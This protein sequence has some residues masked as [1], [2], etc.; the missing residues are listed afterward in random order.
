MD[1]SPLRGGLSLAFSLVIAMMVH[2]NAHPVLGSSLFKE[3]TIWTKGENGIPSHFVYGLTLTPKGTLL[4]FTE[5]RLTPRD[6]DPHH[7]V[8]KR[9]TDQG[10]TWSN[11]LMIERAD[12]TY[13]R[14]QGIE[15]R[16]EC[17]TNPAALVE[18][19][20]GHIFIF[21]AVNEGI[22]TGS[23]NMQ[24]YTRNF[25]RFSR[26]EGLTWSDRVD[27][28]DLLNATEDGRPNKDTEGNWRVD[29]N[30]FP[31]DFLGRAFHMP[32]PGHGLQ[33]KSGR[34]LMQFW[35]RTALGTA[36]GKAIPSSERAYGL[37]LLYSDDQ[38]RSW[39]TG[40]AFGHEG[41]YTESRLVQFNDG[42]LYLNARTSHAHSSQRGILRGTTDGLQWT[43]E[44]LDQAMPRYTPVDS[45]L[46]HVFHKGK[47]WLLLSHP[48]DPKRRRELTLSG[49]SDRGKT[50]AFHKVV[51]NEG[52]N[53][54]D[55]VAFP[56]GTIGLLYAH[57]PSAHQGF[58]V[59]FLRFNAAW[60]GL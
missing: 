41:S 29:V 57:G 23:S 9:S 34:L 20:T 7:L 6:D 39:K 45:G 38:G 31:C 36:D 10:A 33:L 21:Y 52:A 35:N 14:S 49:S 22:V 8:L 1:C 28:T 37:R 18:R 3:S 27:I 30:G 59:K 42:E 53:Y 44:G 50:W 46:L 19:E 43:E 26:D 2:A 13:W 40:P 25:Y 51:H 17:W 15:N 54:S 32:G 24:R 56:D 5:A 60:L 47:E 11:D 4:A 12:G 55:L 58:D 16:L 48:R